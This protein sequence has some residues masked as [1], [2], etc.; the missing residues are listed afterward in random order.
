MNDGANVALI[1]VESGAIP[2]RV[3]DVPKAGAMDVE[4]DGCVV[5]ARVAETPTDGAAKNDPR[6]T[7]PV[8]SRL[9]AAAHA[10]VVESAP[11]PDAVTPTLADGAAVVE[12]FPVLVSVHDTDAEPAIVVDI[13]SPAGV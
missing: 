13:G 3:N 1:E 7:A 11:L 12:S 5:V 9:T 4:I 10:I 2:R 6:L 8:R